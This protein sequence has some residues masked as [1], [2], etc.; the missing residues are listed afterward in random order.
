L[1]LI[2]VLTAIAVL[3]VSAVEPR[4]GSPALSGT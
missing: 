1:T 2:R 4:A 3:L